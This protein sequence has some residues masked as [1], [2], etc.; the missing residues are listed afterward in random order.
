MELIKKDSM[1]VHERNKKGKINDK[2]ITI[3]I[4]AKQLTTPNKH[5]LK[6]KETKR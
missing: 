6:V 2:N 1:R 4:I 5:T 3:A